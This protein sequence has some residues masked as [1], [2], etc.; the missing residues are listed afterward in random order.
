MDYLQLSERSMADRN[1]NCLSDKACPKSTP[2]RGLALDHL[3]GSGVSLPQ[4]LL[5][6]LLWHFTTK[7]SAQI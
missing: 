4:V 7:H 6:L 5:V 1:G 3:R 2:C